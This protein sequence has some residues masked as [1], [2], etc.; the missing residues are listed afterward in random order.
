VLASQ[1]G[2]ES[3]SDGANSAA[4]LGVIFSDILKAAEMTAA[5]SEQIVSA[6]NQQV[7]AFEQVLLAL[8]Q[9]SSGIEDF[10][11]SAKA[12]SSSTENL[13]NMGDEL[14]EIIGK[15]QI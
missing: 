1:K 14:G 12:T 4:K 10:T 13:K 2:T 3:I 6:V 9:I 7:S 5:S 8:K 15:Y 11:S